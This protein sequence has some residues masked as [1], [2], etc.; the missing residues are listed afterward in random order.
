VAKEPNSK[1]LYA[2]KNS[3][4]VVVTMS[5]AINDASYFFVMSGQ[6]IKSDC[7]QRTYEN[8]AQLYPVGYALLDKN[9]VR[10]L[11]QQTDV[12]EM[13]AAAALW[14]VYTN[15]YMPTVAGSLW[16]A[17]QR[18][19]QQQWLE[20]LYLSAVN[21]LA[22]KADEDQR[23]RRVYARVQTQPVLERPQTNPREVFRS[24]EIA[25]IAPTVYG[26]AYEP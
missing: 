7:I 18:L 8:Y 23:L 3:A 16:G 9:L 6:R 20:K 11:A 17:E 22:R 2:K 5:C 26:F 4:F 15:V 10:K 19:T 25:G 13:D 24:R 21:F 12:P 1:C 14:R